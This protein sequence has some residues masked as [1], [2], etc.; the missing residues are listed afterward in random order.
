M[1]REPNLLY[2]VS[3]LKVDL[4]GQWMTQY[5][6]LVGCAP[7]GLPLQCMAEEHTVE[8]RHAITADWISAEY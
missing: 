4:L 6:P 5:R 7:V 2:R 8:F 3:L 1:R